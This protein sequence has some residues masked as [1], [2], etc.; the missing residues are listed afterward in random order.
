M[1][2]PKWENRNF[3]VNGLKKNLNP[4]L[5]EITFVKQ[6]NR[7]LHNIMPWE[8]ENFEFV[9]GGNLK[10]I[11]WLKKTVWSNC[12]SLTVHRKNVAFLKLLLILQPQEATRRYGALSTIYKKH[13][14]LHQSNIGQDVEI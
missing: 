14:L 6:K 4:I 9:W 1:V 3:F 11:D 2:P 12:Y 5:T 7:Q 8:T 10:F 13:N